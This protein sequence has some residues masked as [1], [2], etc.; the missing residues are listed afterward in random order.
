M[1][2]AER[3]STKGSLA[4]NCSDDRRTQHAS[5][6]PVSPWRSYASWDHCAPS[7]GLICT[8]FLWVLR[9][10]SS[11]RS[12]YL[13]CISSPRGCTPARWYRVYSL[14]AAAPTI[15]RQRARARRSVPVYGIYAEP[16]AAKSRVR[17][18]KRDSPCGSPRSGAVY[19]PR[20]SAGT[21]RSP[22][23]PPFSWC[24]PRRAPDGNGLSYA[25]AFPASGARIATHRSQWI[26]PVLHGTGRPH[27]RTVLPTSLKRPNTPFGE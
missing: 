23:G 22:L 11:A 6:A 5:I 1:E 10:R 16:Q 19:I 4:V 17:S 14:A 26:F 2:G 9:G 21:P 12:R 27:Q 24:C 18:G 8:T 20:W 25:S 7:F 15:V 13:P 3:K